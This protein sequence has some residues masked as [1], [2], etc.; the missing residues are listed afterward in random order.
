MPL[1]IYIRDNTP[2]KRGDLIA[3][4]LTPSEQQLGLNRGYLIHGTRCQISEPLI[5]KVIAI[6][7]D[8]VTLTSQHI[9]VNGN[10][11]D[12]ATRLKD[13]KNRLLSPYPRGNYTNTQSYW[14]IGTASLQSWD[15]RYF[16]PIAKNQ[17]LEKIKPLWIFD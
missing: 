4:C 6:P 11:F 15:S 8:N 9:I 1:G 17:M 2:I 10:T 13:S 12:Y 3:F 16:G 14:V 7:H 5:K